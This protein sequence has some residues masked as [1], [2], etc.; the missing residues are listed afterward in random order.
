MVTSLRR[1][2][3]WGLQGFVRNSGASVATTIVMTIV[4]LL[5]TSLY[6]LQYT[7]DFAVDELQD[8]V[9]LTV[10]F[11]EETGEDT[12]LNAKQE[13]SN[14]PAV[15]EASYVL[16]DEALRRFSERHEDDQLIKRAL[17]AVGNNPL[18]PHLNVKAGEPGQ[19]EDLQEYI[20]N[21]AS[22][23]SAV[24]HMNFSE[25]QPAVA[26]INQISTSVTSLGIAL[27]AVFAVIAFLVAFNTVR[28]AIFNLKDEISIMRLVGASNMFVRG[29]LVVQGIV[30]GLLATATALAITAVGVS[31]LD[32]KLAALVSG[33]DLQG[34]FA[35]N[36]ARV[37]GLQLATGI[38]LGVISS[39]IAMR[40]YLQT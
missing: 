35:D 24:D 5:V 11:S 10:Y 17:E 29:P 20:K 25:I 19:Y 3:T 16:Q 21:S 33:L 30:S 23:R 15:S 9:A 22:F 14:M 18:Q 26:K 13:L 7:A 4:I 28:L 39:M 32:P 27:V 6:L 40:R 12:L 2:M 31:V 37:V 36:I 38:G 34:F 8:R 1:I